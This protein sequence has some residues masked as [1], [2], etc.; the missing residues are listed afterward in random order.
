VPTADRQKLV[1]S[2]CFEKTNWPADVAGARLRDDPH[3]PTGDR[4]FDSP[5]VPPVFGSLPLAARRNPRALE[6]L[7]ISITEDLK[8]ACG[9]TEELQR[10]TWDHIQ[11]QIRELNDKLNSLQVLDLRWAIWGLLI[12]LGGMLWGIGT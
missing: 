5:G 8:K 12:T 9:D 7:I 10:K 2:S 6:K 1:L 4:F 11:S 3:E